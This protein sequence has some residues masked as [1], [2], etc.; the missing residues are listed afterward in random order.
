LRRI[1]GALR[2]LFH[3]SPIVNQASGRRPARGPTL[4]FTK[5]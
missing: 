5:A 4:F 2:G 3:R 1:D